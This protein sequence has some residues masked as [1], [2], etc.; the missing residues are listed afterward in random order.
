[1]KSAFFD[2][3][4]NLI[5]E[6][7]PFGLR[8]RKNDG[9]NETQREEPAM[10]SQN[11]IRLLSF[12]LPLILLVG[13][14]S[15]DVDSGDD[16]PE[17]TLSATASFSAT[18]Y[19]SKYDEEIRGVGHQGFVVRSVRNGSGTYDIYV[20]SEELN[21]SFNGL[22]SG[23]PY[24]MS[25]NGPEDDWTILRGPI[26]S[27]HILNE[28]IRLTDPETGVEAEGLV[29]TKATIVAVNALSFEVKEVI[30]LP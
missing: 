24:D 7:E 25:W 2:P 15:V 26:G 10:T 27:E 22:S 3:H 14:D 9:Q 23:D 17:P 19:W 1:V 18:Q 8:G 12:A 5:R 13:C 30:S 16:M 20:R 11:F 21:A 28:T 6:L 29:V 4:E